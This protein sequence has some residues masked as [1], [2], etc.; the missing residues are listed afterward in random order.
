MGALDKVDINLP[1]SVA[2]ASVVILALPLDQIYETLKFIGSEL[3]EDVIV[4]D[5]APIKNGVIQWAK[6]LIPPNRYYIGLTPVLNPAYLDTPGSGVEAAH[7]DLF[8]D[9]MM[10]I[11]SPQ[12]VP[13][14]AIKL[15][16]DF[17][18]L[19]GAEHLFMDP[20]ELDSMMAATHIL[21]Q[22]I[23]AALLNTTVDQPG[24]YE[25]RKL[26]GRPYAAA[27]GAAEQFGEAGSLFSQAI[28]CREHLVRLIDVYMDYLFTLRQQLSS[29][30]AEKLL[31]ELTRA[32][33][34]REKWLK[35]RYT[36]NWAASE[37]APNVQLPTAKEVFSRMF[38][39]GGGR[40]PKQPK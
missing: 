29:N 11:L 14:E 25:A 18:H 30:E 13:S 23:A 17:T 12:G 15:A 5:T 35:E 21:P 27:T 6:E 2:N 36:A 32:Q 40:K 22:L 37:S 33:L 19:L 20:V 26:A 34:G 3:K 24:W 1:S 28:S 7:A 8:K 9:G 39:F 31:P 10:A 16:T 38:T 4:M